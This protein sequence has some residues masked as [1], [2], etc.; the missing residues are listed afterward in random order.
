MESALTVCELCVQGSCSDGW[1]CE[2]VDP[3]QFVPQKNRRRR[4]DADGGTGI[5]FNQPNFYGTTPLTR[6]AK[7]GH[8]L[9]IDA[10]ISTGANVNA[11]DEN[12]RGPLIYAA[13]EGHWQ[14]VSRLVTHGAD[15]NIYADGATPLI[16]AATRGHAMCVLAL[17]SARA[18]LKLPLRK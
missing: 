12:A 1:P 4:L 8:W 5:S 17:I 14:C 6:A 3:K 7:Y 2:R 13:K 11:K 10:L 15:V 18:K 16:H 9:C